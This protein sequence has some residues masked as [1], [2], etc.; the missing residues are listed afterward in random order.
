MFT[1]KRAA[2]WTLA[3]WLVLLSGLVY[4]QLSAHA[5]HHAHHNAA[6]HA[7]ALCSWLCAAGQTAEG[8]VHSGL[9]SHGTSSPA[10][11]FAPLITDVSTYLPT[12]SRG[13]PSVVRPN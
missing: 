8:V 9:T 13:P 1:L 12:V 5:A 11:E 6:T 10:I 7:T 3:G 2:L 4:P